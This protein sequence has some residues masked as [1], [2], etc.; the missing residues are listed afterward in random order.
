MIAFTQEQSHG[1]DCE[2]I[3]QLRWQLQQN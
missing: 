3:H 1:A 2:L